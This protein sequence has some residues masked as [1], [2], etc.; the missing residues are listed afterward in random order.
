MYD[1]GARDREILDLK[2]KDFRAD[3][4]TPCVHLTGKGNKR[5]IVPV[6]AKT[7]E[8]FHNYVKLYY[9]DQ[10]CRRIF[11]LHIKKRYSAANVG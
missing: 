4:K 8:H 7:V 1:T 5:R 6:M 2:V 10:E 3:S 11:V 9:P